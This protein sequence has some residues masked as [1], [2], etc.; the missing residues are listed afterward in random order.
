MAKPK[1]DLLLNEINEVRNRENEYLAHIRTLYPEKCISKTDVVTEELSDKLSNDLNV[2][3]NA[4]VPVKANKKSAKN[5]NN[6]PTYN[7]NSDKFLKTTVTPIFNTNKVFQGPTK[8]GIM[9]QFYTS[10]GKISKDQRK[11]L[12]N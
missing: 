9:Y 2:E 11:S 7:S 6:I 8:K 3:V 1:I 5:Q 4:E 10:R 12:V